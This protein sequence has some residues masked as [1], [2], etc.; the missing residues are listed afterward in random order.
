MYI[1]T[2]TKKMIIFL[3]NQSRLYV[4][5]RAR[6]QKS[7]QK[8]IRTRTEREIQQIPY[9]SLGQNF[10]L[11]IKKKTQASE[12]RGKNSILLVQ[13]RNSKKK[14]FLSCISI[15]KQASARFSDFS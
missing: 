2:Y 14:V 7:L 4:C 11:T 13:A 8:S 3:I 12:K 15:S 1:H 10:A 9:G 6:K 5:A